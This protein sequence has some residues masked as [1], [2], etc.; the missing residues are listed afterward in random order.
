M[1]IHVGVKRRQREPAEFY[2]IAIAVLL[3]D[4]IGARF[5]VLQLNLVAD[6]LDRLALRWIGARSQG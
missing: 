6:Q 1:R 4:D 2:G 3:N 5:L